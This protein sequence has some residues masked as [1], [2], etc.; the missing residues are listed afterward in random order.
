MNNIKPKLIRL[1]TKEDRERTIR[2]TFIQISS[3]PSLL[4]VFNDGNIQ[5]FNG[6]NKIILWLRKIIDS[7][8]NRDNPHQHHPYNG[9]YF[10]NPLHHLSPQPLP[11]QPNT[12]HSHPP[13]YQPHPHHY[14]LPHK[15]SHLQP[16]KEEGNIYSKHSQ[17][18][19]KYNETIDSS[20][21]EEEIK[22]KRIKPSKKKKVK[23]GSG[24]KSRKETRTPQEDSDEDIDFL[25]NEENI[26]RQPTSNNLNVKHSSVNKASPMKD[27]RSAA[28]QMRKEAGENTLFKPDF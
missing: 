8:E 15:P 2:G 10:P 14:Q 7:T 25:D 22:R 17:K 24:K 21:S 13:H 26:P 12:P 9:G 20:S 16:Q 5:V 6:Q 18:E 23:K 28:E 3:V 19:E 4:V 27:I 1:D 11:P